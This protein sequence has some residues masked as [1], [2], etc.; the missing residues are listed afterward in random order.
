MRTPGELFRSIHE[1][2]EPK[3]LGEEGL[4]TPVTLNTDAYYAKQ[5]RGHHGEGGFFNLFYGRN[6]DRSGVS[7][8]W[9]KTKFYEY[10]LMHEAF[11]DRILKIEGA[12]EPRVSKDGVAFDY[13]GIRPVTLTKAVEGDAD[14]RKRREEIVSQVYTSQEDEEILDEQ[15]RILRHRNPRRSVAA[16]YRVDKEM[17]AAFGQDL[18]VRDFIAHDTFEQQ[19]WIELFVE[20]VN[21]EFPGTRVAEMA[22]AGIVP[23]HA[24]FNFIPTAPADERGANGVFLEAVI[25][26]PARL[27]KTLVERR[28]Q[29]LGPNADRQR[30]EAEVADKVNRY[31]VLRKLDETYDKLFMS[32]HKNREDD[33]G[34]VNDRVAVADV[35]RAFDRVRARV[36][37]ERTR[38]DE[39]FFFGLYERSLRMVHGDEERRAEAAGRLAAW[40]DA[41]KPKALT[42]AA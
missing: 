20:V 13:R 6:V 42:K 26:D 7:P 30:I 1:S 35:Y 9:V 16:A 2:K 10:S 24:E 3:F 38:F 28:V 31:L 21:E 27:M 22:N 39:D 29:E 25:F 40:I 36:D 18:G 8:F 15:G 17:R 34:G 5:W 19:D 41:W 37:R 12:V 14:L 11:P 4:L 23:V 33:S 32:G